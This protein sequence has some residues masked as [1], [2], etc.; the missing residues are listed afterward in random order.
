MATGNV[1]WFNADKGYGFI[2]P[3]NGGEDVFV[4]VTAVQRAGL[5]DLNENKKVNFAVK[6]RRNGKEAVTD[7]QAQ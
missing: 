3:H 4:H 1:K 5:D 7:I 2:A 6:T